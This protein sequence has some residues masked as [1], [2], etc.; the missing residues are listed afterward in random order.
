M[1]WLFAVETRDQISRRRRARP[2]SIN[3]FESQ[4]R[5]AFRQRFRRRSLPAFAIGTFV[6]LRQSHYRKLRLAERRAEVFVR[7]FRVEPPAPLL[8]AFEQK[9]QRLCDLR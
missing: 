6:K 4:Y 2:N 9:L 7:L 1:H 3:L 8:L 5:V